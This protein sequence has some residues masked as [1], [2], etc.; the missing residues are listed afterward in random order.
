MTGPFFLPNFGY[1][2]HK[3]F[4]VSS[5]F[6][7]LHSYRSSTAKTIQG[8]LDPPMSSASSTSSQENSSPVDSQVDTKLPEYKLPEYK[9]VK[10]VLLVL[11]DSKEKYAEIRHNYRL[12]GVTTL[13]IKTVPTCSDHLLAFKNPPSGQEFTQTP[14]YRITA[15]HETHCPLSLG[16]LEEHGTLWQMAAKSDDLQVLDFASWVATFPHTYVPNVFFRST[17][18]W[19]KT[20]AALLS[21][22]RGEIKEVASKVC[23]PALSCE[24]QLNQQEGCAVI[25]CTSQVQGSLVPNREVNGSRF[26][27]WDGY[28]KTLNSNKHMGVCTTKCSPR[29]TTCMIPFHYSG[30]ISNPERCW[31][32]NTVP[33]QLKTQCINFEYDVFSHLIVPMYLNPNEQRGQLTQKWFGNALNY[34]ANQGIVVRHP[35]NRRQNNYFA[36]GTNAFLCM[37]QK[38]DPMHE[39]VYF[40]HDLMHMLVFDLLPVVFDHGL[41]VKEVKAVY[42]ATRL[43]SELMT[44]PMGDMLFVDLMFQVGVPYNTVEDRKIYPMFHTAYPKGL[45]GPQDIPVLLHKSMDFGLKNDRGAFLPAD[46]PKAQDFY[47]KYAAYVVMDGMWSM[48]NAENLV[49]RSDA[50]QRWYKKYELLL[51]RLKLVT[52]NEFWARVVQKRHEHYVS[53]H[54]SMD[55][56]TAL[57]EILIDDFVQKI[58]T[59]T[60]LDSWADRQQRAFL[61]WAVFQMLIFEVELK[62]WVRSSHYESILHSYLLDADIRNFVAAYVDML[63][64]ARIDS[65]I[66][67]NSEQ[68]FSGVYPFFPAN[69]IGYDYRETNMQNQINLL[70]ADLPQ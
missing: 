61:R 59:P 50:I 18:H 1:K 9:S 37:T 27:G 64:K 6:Q 16:I 54:Q 3:K 11:T 2:K 34:M 12:N 60:H 48:N 63:Q 44:L 62:E 38:K 32:L 17:I 31:A 26:F 36:P 29:D 5:F 7:L 33:E 28:F 39:Q 47:D 45:S 49:A 24:E 21:F 35:T 30:V 15:Q 40:F 41:S 52:V 25:A 4:Q 13:M 14:A 58:M 67:L 66:T 46:D 19:Y 51:K 56:M 22:Q 10:P 53:T 8:E 43:M 55:T 65:R 68:C 69:Y 42:A 23:D 20:V 70:F 57:R